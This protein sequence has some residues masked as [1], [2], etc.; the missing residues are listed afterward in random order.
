MDGSTKD[1]KQMID[2]YDNSPKQEQE[3]FGPEWIIDS[4]AAGFKVIAQ[5]GGSHRLGVTKCSNK[6]LADD[7]NGSLNTPPSDCPTPPSMSNSSYDHI[8]HSSLS[9]NCNRSHKVVGSPQSGQKHTRDTV[10]EGP[11]M[12]SRHPLDHPFAQPAHA[13]TP[14]LMY[15]A[16][17]GF[18]P[19]AGPSTISM[20]LLAGNMFPTHPVLL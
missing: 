3:L 9:S 7:Q 2:T 11:S 8:P 17:S 18:E 16:C 4:V 10:Y 14:Y 12:H 19:P 13:H 20:Q 1:P 15:I 5:N 6:H